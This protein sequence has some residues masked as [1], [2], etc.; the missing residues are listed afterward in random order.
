MWGSLLAA[1]EGEGPLDGA[2][3]DGHKSRTL[4]HRGQSDRLSYNTI[5]HA[6]THGFRHG[7]ILPQQEWN[8]QAHAHQETRR[9]RRKG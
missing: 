5:T 6:Q 4:V 7:E 2:D 9:G 8:A 3:A 1:L